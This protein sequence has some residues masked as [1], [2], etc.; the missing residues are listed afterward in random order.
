MQNFVVG[1]SGMGCDNIRCTWT[2]VWCW[3]VLPGEISSR[4]FL[5]VPTGSRFQQHGIR[6]IGMCASA[7]KV[8]IPARNAVVAQHQTCVHVQ[9]TWTSQQEAQQLRS[10]QHVCKRKPLPPPPSA[11]SLDLAPHQGQLGFIAWLG[12]VFVWNHAESPRIN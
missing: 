4:G 8:N 9:G 12:I 6:A 2:H 5:N 10:I 1:C 11:S 7:R 3:D